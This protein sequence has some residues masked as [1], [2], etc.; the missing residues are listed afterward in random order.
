MEFIG[1]INFWGLVEQ[2]RIW[3]VL[4]FASVEFF[5]RQRIFVKFVVTFQK[6]SNL[7][8]HFLDLPAQ[9]D[10]V[11]PIFLNEYLNWCLDWYYL[12]N[13]LE[14]EDIWRTQLVEIFAIHKNGH[15]YVILD[16][17]R[18]ISL[19]YHIFSIVCHKVVQ[20]WAWLWQWSTVDNHWNPSLHPLEQ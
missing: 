16:E 13:I 19:K 12:T 11:L 15:K 6:V 2:Q 14:K 10:K 18:L 8:V 4:V 20:F 7:L 17:I 1:T 9:A 5:K 3:P